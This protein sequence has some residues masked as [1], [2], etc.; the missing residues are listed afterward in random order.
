VSKRHYP[1]ICLDGLRKTT[2][3]FCQDT[4]SPG[5]DLNPGSPECEAGVLTTRPEHSVEFTLFL[6]FLLLLLLLL[7]DCNHN[8]L[9]TEHEVAVNEQ[10]TMAYVQKLNAVIKCNNL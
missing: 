4:Q 7:L 6:L 8:T 2:N 10:V 5:R 1:G 9:T 3:D